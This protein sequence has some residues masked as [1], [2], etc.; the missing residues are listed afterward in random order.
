MGEASA[1]RYDDLP[2]DDFLVCLMQHEKD[3]RAGYLPT[4]ASLKEARLTAKLPPPPAG[5]GAISFFL[6]Q[7]TDAISQ[8]SEE[9]V[10]IAGLGSEA[11]RLRDEAIA[12]RDFLKNGG[13]PCLL[14]I[15]PRYGLVCGSAIEPVDPSVRWDRGGAYAALYLVS[16]PGS[17]SLAVM[18]YI[19]QE[20][21]R[22]FTDLF[23]KYN[24]VQ[25]KSPS[26]LADA[27]KKLRG[28][29]LAAQAGS[30][31][32]ISYRQVKLAARFMK[33]RALSPAF[34]SLIFKGVK[35]EDFPSMLLDPGRAVE[36]AEHHDRFFASLSELAS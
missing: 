13:Q 9:I 2:L 11:P 23:V 30:T 28:V 17:P 6:L 22:R 7:E 16:D 18:E 20:Q 26:F 32:R 25:P 19:A 35:K 12:L 29:P 5:P 1:L 31:P 36:T 8:V 21:R 3:V 33:S 24:Q 10:I 4:A 27:W 14:R 34:I 15:D